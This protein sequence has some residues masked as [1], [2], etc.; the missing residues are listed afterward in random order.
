MSTVTVWIVI[1]QWVS[2]ATSVWAS[3]AT[4]VSDHQIS[5]AGGAGESVQHVTAAGSEP[6]G[7]VSSA[8]FVPAS[9]SWSLYTSPPVAVA[10]VST[11]S[12][13]VASTWFNP[14]DIITPG[15]SRTLR[16]RIKQSQHVLAN[17]TH[18]LENKN[19]ERCSG[20]TLNIDYTKDLH[21]NA[22]DQA[23][24]NS[25]FL[26]N[27]WAWRPHPSE[28]C[29]SVQ[30]GVCRQDD[31]SS[32]YTDH[33][34]TFERIRTAVQADKNVFAAGG[35]WG[36]ERMSSDCSLTC[37]YARRNMTYEEA[38]KTNNSENYQA[39]AVEEISYVPV[40]FFIPEDVE[41][42]WFVGP[43]SNFNAVP[44]E[45][46]RNEFQ[47]RVLTGL[48]NSSP[49]ATNGH[50][51]EHW[52]TH[53]TYEHGYW[54]RP[55]FD[56]AIGGEWMISFMMPIVIISSAGKLTNASVEEKIRY[57]GTTGVDIELS[58][59]D[60]DQCQS[61][62]NASQ[63]FSSDL[64]DTHFCH[65][66]T[67]CVHVPKGG[68]KSGSYQCKC[69]PAYY[70]PEDETSSYDGGFDG[71]TIE[72]F[73]ERHR[74]AGGIC[75]EAEDTYACIASQIS[76]EF[77]CLPCHPSCKTCTNGKSCS[78]KVSRP[79]VIA[80]WVLNLISFVA[81]AGLIVFVVRFRDENIVKAASWPF[82]VTALVGAMLLY[83][84]GIRPIISL[85]AMKVQ[86]IL[87]V[88]LEVFGFALLYG[89]IFLK[90]WRIKELISPKFLK[91]KLVRGQKFSGRTIA[92]RLVLLL[93]FTGVF[94]IVWTVAKR[95]TVRLVEP[96]GKLSYYRCDTGPFAY[97]MSA[98]KTLFLLLKL[99]LKPVATR[100][101][102]FV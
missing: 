12:N 95:P 16:E 33:L 57:V 52:D 60:I 17:I 67:E 78:Y 48:G 90:I 72:A 6:E 59:V 2:N 1:S 81:C 28:L 50:Q 58:K 51:S 68:F 23:V 26:S 76:L 71:A 94:V 30:P 100:N 91:K 102:K 14:N 87:D 83:A 82:L 8:P 55:Y 47:Y 11:T 15:R 86:C 92:R 37:V 88:F 34:V 80:L 77:S 36:T 89:S 96:A 22:A 29:E 39:V 3:S 101:F 45:E 46:R 18:A 70:P 44:V 98:G 32:V 79:L 5:A 4:A 38:R 20:S 24:A 25:L 65:E 40:E 74:Q 84:A 49:E 63:V 97:A 69:R 99:L 19:L 27:L 61:H 54:T 66:S 31:H 21:R 41:P 75:H 13:S 62:V 9:S 7:L 53:V 42:E 56:C 10:S 64:A 35:C 85:Q 73:A 43:R 93:V